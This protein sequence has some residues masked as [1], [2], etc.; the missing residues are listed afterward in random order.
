MTKSFDGG[1]VGL[2]KPKKKIPTWLVIVIILGLTFAICF[3]CIAVVV[4]VSLLMLALQGNLQD[5][6]FLI[7]PMI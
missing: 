4:I 1:V 2:E 5:F 6:L 7:L 3:C